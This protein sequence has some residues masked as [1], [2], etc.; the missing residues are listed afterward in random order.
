M[1]F[2][3]FR[4]EVPIQDMLLHLAIFLPLLMMAFTVHELCHGLAAYALGDSTAKRGGRLSL[5]PIRHIDPI[6]FIAILVAGIGWAKPV[7]VNPFALKNP[8]VDM[9][10]IAAAGPLSNFILAFVFTMVFVFTAINFNL[11]IMVYRAM[12][13]FVRINLVLGVFNLI[14]VPPL[15]GSKIIAGALPD[16]VYRQLPHHLARYSMFIVLILAV[17]GL[18]G[19]I[20]FPITDGLYS[21]FVNIGIRIFG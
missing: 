2:Q 8:K 7:M 14:P 16:S 12:A 13:D 5:N 11:P 1:I 9:A 10:L 18:L 6:G 19:R 3:L 21:A 4:A 20:I 17:S 15:D